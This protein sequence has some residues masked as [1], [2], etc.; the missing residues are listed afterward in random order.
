MSLLLKSAS[1]AAGLVIAA[2][3]VGLFAGPS[4][5]TQT[6]IAAPASQVWQELVN[7]KAYSEWNPFIKHMSG[8][9]TVGDQLK[10]TIQPEGKA[11]MNFTPNVLV[12]DES[13]ELRWVGRLGFK[14]VFDG[15]HYFK[16]EETSKGTTL[17]HHGEYFKGIL[18][19]P[20]FALIGKDTENGF[21][22]MNE[23]LKKRVETGV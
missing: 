7:G 6:E 13:K 18:A 19:Y 5:R 22:A 12:A 21:N 8:D 10:V 14:G 3:G 20:L 23:A 15:E 2:Y 11:P 9:L 16:L 4:I 17:L 1:I